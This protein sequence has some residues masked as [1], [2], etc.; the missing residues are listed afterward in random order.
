[1][2]PML[3]NASDEREGN[4]LRQDHPRNALQVSRHIPG[5]H[6]HRIEQLPKPDREV[7]HA[8][9]EVSQHVAVL[10]RFAPTIVASTGADAGGA[11]NTPALSSMAPPANTSAAVAV[12]AGNTITLLA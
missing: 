8:R 3:A 4:C 6:D 2:G 7:A 1:M 5:H 10:G 12:V 11:A 9:A